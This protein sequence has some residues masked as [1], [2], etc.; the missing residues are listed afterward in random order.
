MLD[1]IERRLSVGESVLVHCLAGAHR[2][3][4]QSMG[5]I[6]VAILVVERRLVLIHC[7]AGA[8]GLTGKSS[9]V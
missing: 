4:K 5:V 7:L 8:M 6:K 2:Q 3:E 9:Q 1:F